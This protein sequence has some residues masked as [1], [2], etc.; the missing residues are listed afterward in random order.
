MKVIVK[1]IV[2]KNAIYLNAFINLLNYNNI[3]QI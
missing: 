3:N 2:L 1:N